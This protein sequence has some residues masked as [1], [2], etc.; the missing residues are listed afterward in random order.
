MSKQVEG[1][2][3]ILSVGEKRELRAKPQLQMD[4][5]SLALEERESWQHSHS[6]PGAENSVC[7]CHFI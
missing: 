5:A 4:L 7:S 6:K 2:E 3:A 1:R